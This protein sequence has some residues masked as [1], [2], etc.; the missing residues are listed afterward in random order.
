MNKLLLL[1]VVAA[2][3][4]AC[5]SSKDTQLPP[6]AVEVELTPLE[7]GQ[8][9]YPGYTAADYATGK[10][11]YGKK[12]ST[13]HDL[14]KVSHESVEGW[15][16]TVPSMVALSNKEGMPITASEEDLITKYLVATRTK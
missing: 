4:Y 3:I 1:T 8:K 2:G 14:P 13:C 9:L 11:L 16:K 5:K 6:P 7:K 12:C 15:K 10:E